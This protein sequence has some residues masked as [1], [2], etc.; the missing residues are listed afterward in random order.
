MNTGTFGFPDIRGFCGCFHCFFHCGTRFA[1]ERGFS[2]LVV[3]SPEKMMEL[4]W[5]WSFALLFKHG[6]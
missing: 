6:D 3:G 4:G 1:E 2:A 5:R